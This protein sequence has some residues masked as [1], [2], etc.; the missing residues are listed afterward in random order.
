MLILQVKCEIFAISYA[1]HKMIDICT[2]SLCSS[3]ESQLLHA[4]LSTV[5]HGRIMFIQYNGISKCS[6]NI[7]LCTD[8]ISCSGWDSYS[9]FFYLNILCS[10]ISSYG[11][12]GVRCNM[13]NCN[14][15]LPS[16][17]I[18]THHYSFKS[19]CSLSSSFIH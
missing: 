13:E 17:T 18:S 6:I 4:A 9:C 15:V 8:A 11:P 14:Y 10:F 7:S 5:W 1:W 16:V 3:K 19:S 2:K 12:W